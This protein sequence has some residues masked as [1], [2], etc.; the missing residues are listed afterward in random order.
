VSYFN[1]VVDRM[2]GSGLRNVTLTIT[3]DQIPAIFE[4][5][6]NARTPQREEKPLNPDVATINTPTTSAKV[7]TSKAEEIEE[8]QSRPKS[9]AENEKT[10][11]TTP[12][13][14]TTIENHDVSKIKE[15]TQKENLSIKEHSRIE[16]ASSPAAEPAI[17]VKSSEQV[18]KNMRPK[19]KES[20][21]KGAVAREPAAGRAVI[22]KDKVQDMQESLSPSRGEPMVGARI[23]EIISK[24]SPDQTHREN[25]IVAFP[26]TTTAAMVPSQPEKVPEH[27]HLQRQSNAFHDTIVTINI[28]RIEVRA[29][30]TTHN[31][32]V[33]KQTPRFTPPLTLAE[34]LKQRQERGQ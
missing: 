18:H 32:S 24:Q 2:L 29:S 28:G 31:D 21:E 7:I 14:R 16:E 13:T 12:S 26:T 8:Q 10:K 1:R 27:Q 3:A 4:I 23:K 19:D 5:K 6:K 15:D 25:L 9:S 34:Y 20:T 11:K 33:P 17:A 30:S 22:D